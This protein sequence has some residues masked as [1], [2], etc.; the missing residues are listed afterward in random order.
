MTLNFKF[1][2][3][4]SFPTTPLPVETILKTL[5]NFCHH[6]LLVKLL[7]KLSI[8]FRNSRDFKV[9]KMRTVKKGNSFFQPFP[10]YFILQSLQKLLKGNRR[11]PP[12]WVYRPLKML[13]Q[14]R[15]NT[16]GANLHQRRKT[17]KTGCQKIHQ[18]TFLKTN[19]INAQIND[20]PAV[21]LQCILQWLQSICFKFK[22]KSGL[23]VCQSTVAIGNLKI[24]VWQNTK[25]QWSVPILRP[26]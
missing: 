21:R 17:F 22:F 25:H 4:P 9:N 19:P 24:L 3:F 13:I 14:G 16:K 2:Q 15:Q 10:S 23:S 5:F 12:F 11:T 26:V 20:Q 18:T 1:H 7:S 6:K 8:E